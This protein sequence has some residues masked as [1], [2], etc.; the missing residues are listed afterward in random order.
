LFFLDVWPSKLYIQL[1]NCWRENKNKFVIGFAAWLV[2]AKVF[3][4]VKISFLIKGHTHE[5]V[6][7]MFSL[8]SKRL[9]I[10]S[11]KT[12]SQYQHSIRFAVDGV[13]LQMMNSIFDAKKFLEPYLSDMHN[14]TTPHHFV[15]FLD[16]SGQAMM[17]CKSYSFTKYSQPISVF[18]AEPPTTLS[19]QTAA[20]KPVNWEEKNNAFARCSSALTSAEQ[21]EWRQW[22]ETHQ[23]STPAANISS[24]ILDALNAKVGVASRV[25]R[26]ALPPPR[27]LPSITRAASSDRQDVLALVAPYIVGSSSSS[28]L[29]ESTVPSE[30]ITEQAPVEWQT[31]LGDDDPPDVYVGPRRE[32]QMWG[33]LEQDLEVGDMILI[34]KEKVDQEEPWWMGKV[35]EIYKQQKKLLVQWYAKVAGNRPGTPVSW[36]IASWKEWYNVLTQEIFEKLSPEEQKKHKNKKGTKWMKSTET[37]NLDPSIIFFYGFRLNSNNKIPKNAARNISLRM[38][39]E[40]PIRLI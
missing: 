34:L 5:N 16:D 38:E 27:L 39:S 29:E 25:V 19:F 17:R 8:V 33:N 26:P 36:E 9:H 28:T 14:H 40:I 18:H 6:D 13:Q 15:L 3:K 37:I 20:V 11:P 2:F 22:F 30:S 12:I 10:D 32:K 4:K 24:E 35:M 7:R 21:E 1:D 23:D 31:M